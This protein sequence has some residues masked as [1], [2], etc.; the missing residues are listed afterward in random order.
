M[1]DDN[2]II[3]RLDQLI[4][5]LRIGFAESLDRARE[6]VTADPVASTILEAT[7]DGWVN[8]GN[9]QRSVSQAATVSGRTVLRSMA[10]LT[11]RGLLRVRGSGRATSYR[12]SDVL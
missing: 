7:K 2:G 6:E 11:D 3:E 9:L 12:S 4:A 5:L 1:S 8:S 10:G